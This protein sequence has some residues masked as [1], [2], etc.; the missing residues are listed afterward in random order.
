M[1]ARW[2]VFLAIAVAGLT[3][4]LVTKQRFF[5]QEYAGHF[6]DPSVDYWVWEGVLGTQPSLNQGAL[7][8]IGKGGSAVLAV[9]AI[10]AVIGR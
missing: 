5:D 4:D 8:G 9:V 2:L 7:F 1:I 10:V 6:S 3:V